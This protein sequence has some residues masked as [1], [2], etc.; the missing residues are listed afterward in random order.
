MHDFQKSLLIMIAT[1]SLFASASSVVSA[2]EGVASARP[3]SLSAPAKPLREGGLDARIRDLHDKLHITDS[4]SKDWDAIAQT[5]RENTEAMRKVIIERH[6]KA[7]TLNAI[8]DLNLYRRAAEVHLENVTRLSAAFTNLYNTMSDE[9]KKIADEVF[10]RPR[11]YAEGHPAG[12][13]SV[14]AR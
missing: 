9:Q 5:M 12:M 11:S 14:T 13:P 6:A 2:A 1:V 3:D 10:R 8:D 7:D 4:Q